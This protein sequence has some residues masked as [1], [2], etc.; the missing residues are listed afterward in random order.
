MCVNREL[1][2]FVKH[3]ASLNQKQLAVFVGSHHSRT[4]KFLVGHMAEMHRK[5]L[6]ATS[7]F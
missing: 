4:S 6:M 3:M 1:V 7:Y 2:L 5:W